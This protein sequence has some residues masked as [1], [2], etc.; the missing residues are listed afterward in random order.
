[1]KLTNIEDADALLC[2]AKHWQN[3]QNGGV[4]MCPIDFWVD[5]PDR[6]E[7]PKPRPRGLKGIRI[8]WASAALSEAAY[9]ADCELETVSP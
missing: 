9:L 6:D 8:I 5:L 1:M 3:N 4:R 7:L 2:A